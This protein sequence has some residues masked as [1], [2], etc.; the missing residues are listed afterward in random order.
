MRGVADIAKPLHKLTDPYD[1]TPECQKAF[2][3]LRHALTTSPILSFPI[4]GKPFIID[5]DASVVGLV[6]VLLGIRMAQNTLLR[7]TVCAFQK[8]SV[9]IA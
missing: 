5:T 4:P 2:E 3:A 6:T 8:R 9:S 7:V 1:W